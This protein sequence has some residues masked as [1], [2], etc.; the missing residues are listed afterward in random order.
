[1]DNDAL[2]AVNR[3]SCYSL[4]YHL[5]VVTKYRHPVLTGNIEIRLKE[6]T[7]RL[8]TE[9][10]GG[11][12]IRMECDKDHIHIL[13]TSP[14]QLALSQIADVYKTVTSR[15]LKKEFAAELAPYYWKEALWSR[16]YFIGT[17]SNRT[18][19]AVQAYI[20]NQKSPEHQRKRGRPKKN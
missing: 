12:V 15:L 10:F 2:Y 13:F 3:H 1:M 7:R 5:V 20:A 11:R 6:I 18:D 4:E 17:V 16:S 8:F 9:N 19:E 14:P